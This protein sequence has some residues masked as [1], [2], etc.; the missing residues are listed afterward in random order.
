[1]ENTK[2]IFTEDSIGEVQLFSDDKKAGKMDISVSDRKLR[3]Y[4]IEVHPEYEGKGF[5]KLLLNQLISY[6]F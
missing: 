5:A 6:V 1:M 2:V 4:L 3:L